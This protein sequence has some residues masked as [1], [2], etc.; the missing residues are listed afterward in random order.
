MDKDLR[1]RI[2]RATQAARALLEREL[3]EQLEGRFDLRRDGTIGAEPGVHLEGAE[4]VLRRKLVMAVEHLRA[5]GLGSAEAVAA[6]LREASFTALNRFVA[7]KMLEARGLVQ[8]CVSQG[9]RSAGFKEF[10]GLAP[11]LVALDDGGYRLYLESLF[12]EI[13]REVRV[14]FDR[15][16]P[17]GLLW[18]R[19]PALAELLEI[20]NAPEL[21]EVWGQDETIGWVYQ[22][23]N[24][25]DER[26]QMR[27]ESQAPRN[28]WELAVR[29]QFFTPRYVVEFLTDNTLGRLWGEM[30]AGAGG[31]GE[32]RLV[33]VCEFLVERGE[34]EVRSRPAKD[35]R[36][37][38]VLD[39][40]CGSG[41]FLLYAFDLL[42]V[43][44]EEAWEAG[45]GSVDSGPVSEVSGHS[46]R[47][48]YPTLAEL[49]SA[50]PGL[51]LRHNLHGIEIDPRAAQIAAL[52]LWMRAQRALNDFGIDRRER[53]AI[54][55]TNV[56]VAEP[57]PGEEGLRREFVAGLE[58]M[59]GALVERV[60]GCME[61]AGELG[62]LLRIEEEIGVA[63]REVYGEHG[64]LF[65][66]QDEEQ[67]Q[68]AETQL[69]AA[70][71]SYAERAQDEEAY[72]RRLFAEDAARG[73]ALVDVL[74]RRYDVVLM[75]PPFGAASLGAKKDFERSYPRTK[76]DLYAAFVERGIGLLHPRGLLGAITSRTGFFL[77]SF[78]KWR[79]EILLQEAPPVVFA[80]LG[81]GVMDAALVE[82]AAYCLE[83]GLQ[84]ENVETIFLR[85]L[86][87]AHDKESVLRTAI[88]KPE[89]V[90][91]QAY[92]QVRLRGLEKIRRSPFAY[93]VS[94]SLRQLFSE[95]PAFEA[96]RRTAKQG[97]ATAA[98]PRFLRLWWEVLAAVMRK[99]WFPFAKGGSYS[100]FYAALNLV[101]N[102]G[103][104]GVEVSNLFKP[105]SSRVASRPQNIDFY[106]RP[107]FTW[108]RRT[109]SELSFRTLPAGCVF[110]DKGPAAF[111]D[112]NEPSDLLTFLCLGVSKPFRALVEVQL[113]AAEPTGRGGVARSYEVGVI[114][115]TPVP[116][117]SEHDRQKLASLARRAW[118][119]KRSLD[120]RTETS[121]AFTLPA[122]LQTEGET[123]AERATAW[124]ARERETEAE[125]AAIQAEIDELCFDLYGIEDQDRRAITE[126]FG[127]NTENDGDDEDDD[128]EDDEDE[129]EVEPANVET[130]VAEL[131][132]WAVG[133]AFG[134]FDARLATG[135]R[136]LPPEPE[137]F[138]PLPT[139]SPAMLQDENGQ[140]LEP[141]E[142]GPLVD[143]P[144]H[145]NDLT[146]AVRDVFHQVFG[147]AADDRWREVAEALDPK[148]RELRAWLAK[149]FFEHH[150]KSHSKSRRKAP[151]LWQL[152]TPSASY[153]TWLYAHRL[154]TDTFYQLLGDHISPKLGHE[155]KKL[156][157]LLQNHGSSPTASQ[158]KELA[159]QERFVEE[160]RTLREE[161]ERI[162][163][164]WNPHLDDGVLINFAPLWH[165]VPQHKAW[166]RECKKCWKKLA[167]GD[168]D[169]SHLA[170][171]L[172]PERVVPQCA[173]DRS[174]AIAHELE[175]AFWAE[176]DDGKWQSRDVEP[177][178]VEKL[179]AERT[180]PAVKAALDSLMESSGARRTERQARR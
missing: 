105:G 165:L 173:T 90:W 65:Q 17:A 138:D 77:S 147:P 23:F 41:H 126:G 11:G 85:A 67:W 76:N 89:T 130:L 37:L 135:E 134:R 49:R 121:H 81:L 155:E 21:A 66:E 27:A 176:D 12:D 127:Q 45:S 104:E 50:L 95:L 116:E 70:L 98:D 132:A 9:E 69:L 112:G 110:A 114:Q 142:A 46:L 139:C 5:G 149:S 47:E 94:R 141:P 120:T 51:V 180:S 137:P 84:E 99:R 64:P 3:G 93:W 175:D 71:R 109:K 36:D 33:E 16:D 122:L 100:R 178:T 144:G 136:E 118:L 86:E 73:F 103:R 174:L 18:P 13:G 150:L 87:E 82:A 156:A 78:Q 25:E 170:L 68:K 54:A 35:P 162:A 62:S 125:L 28:G 52:A 40:A 169:W 167:S 96:D 56:V 75:N 19:R 115:R 166:Q 24:S 152:A 26:R 129:I 22:Y 80:D 1:N 88:A 168:Y 177:E 133:V 4:R 101:V 106:F 145:P 14:L 153:S 38:R 128:K 163:P 43:I 140:P 171:H 2:Q 117:L 42:L 91:G 158:R 119:L 6:H 164:L 108:T 79:E 31:G 172:W 111:V 29:N 154:S 72:R 107:G 48:D 92:F 148:N 8:E 20:L 15:R 151:I 113:A 83:V 146:N 157:D 10:A 131:V 30:R 44:Y 58:E 55:R 53:P 59:L 179:I 34:E 161:I 32:T 39:P 97:L 159:A 160:L 143:D 7:L 102:W 60:F 74:W 124:A 63:I 57:M 123:L 61:R